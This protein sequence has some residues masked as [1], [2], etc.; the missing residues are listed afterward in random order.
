MHREA[1]FMQAA[2]E[3]ADGFIVLLSCMI[4]PAGW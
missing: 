2:P 1:G 4:D 3:N